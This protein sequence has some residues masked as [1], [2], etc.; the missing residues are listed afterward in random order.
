[1]SRFLLL[2]AI[3]LSLLPGGLAS[4]QPAAPLYESCRL[5][6]IFP[7]GG[8]RGTTVTVDFFANGNYTGLADAKDIV[9]DGP[10]GIR[11]KEIK[12][13]K[14]HEVR[15]TLEISADAP[16]G[17]RCVRVLSAGSGLTNMAWFVVGSLPEIVESEPNNDATKPQD[18]TAPVVIN[19]QISPAAD[20]DVFRFHAKSGQKLVACVVAYAIDTHGQGRDYGIT[21]T[22]LTI[23]DPERRVIAEAQ[24]TLG[25]DP[26]AEFTAASDGQYLVKV[27]H[28]SFRGYP[29]AVYR[30]TIGE[31]P[32]VTS[33]FP[34]GGRRGEK[35]SVELNGP[36]I[37]DGTRREVVIP[38]DEKSPVLYLTADGPAA[39]NHDVPFLVNDQPE[40][41]EAEPN[42]EFVG[43]TKL[44][45]PVTMNGKFAKSGDIDC[46]RV[47]LRAGET[48][49]VETT[50]HR[51]LRGPADTRVEI[52][53][54]DGKLL[55]E[56]D[57]G[58][59]LDY[60][61]MHDYLSTD[62][63]LSFKAPKDGDYIVR[64]REAAGLFGP[65]A[66]YRLSAR[67]TTPDFQ[68]WQFPDGVPIWGPGST[69]GLIVKIDRLAGYEGNVELSLEGLP[70][71]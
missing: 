21:D 9:I 7:A 43:A 27:Q 52:L 5:E 54:A 37:P 44:T 1:M 4:A 17:R 14:P 2:L 70:A 46:Y 63:R 58:F 61:W 40:G 41:V 69:A 67:L 56:N 8:Q 10:P 6:S 50:A 60:M 18:V 68:L 59:A 30:L 49:D 28:N 39:G 33:V 45:L 12:N 36:N 55:A 62:S 66:V 71:G 23:V 47:T 51:F 13:L 65:R 22:E 24:D 11:V 15:A 34:P 20:V 42:D 35:V 29:Q 32:I 3:A 31:V 38:A 64:V 25:L 26:L 57:D 19:G 16:P 48:L 53:D